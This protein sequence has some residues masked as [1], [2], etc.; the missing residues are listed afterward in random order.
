MRSGAVFFAMAAA[1]ILDAAAYQ[2]ESL[3]EVPEG[4]TAAGHPD[5]STPMF[6]R[7]AMTQPN[8]GLFEQTLSDIS[9][10]GHARYGQH[11]KRDQLKAM[12]RPAADATSVVMSWLTDAGV[13]QETIEDG[14]YSAEMLQ[15]H[16]RSSNQHFYRWRMDQLCG[17]Q[18]DCR[19]E[20]DG[21]RVRHLQEQRRYQDPHSTLLHPRELARVCP[22]YTLKKCLQHYSPD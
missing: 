2:L 21:D 11:L 5:P 17:A 12:L 3:N 22:S 20:D 10:P 16:N 19:R 13:S 18:H 15:K 8:Q 1:G 6:F 9:T 14:T 7:I 4:W